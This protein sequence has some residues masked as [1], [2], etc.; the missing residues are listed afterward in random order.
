MSQ[1][2]KANFF[3]SLHVPGRPLVLYNIWDAGSARALQEAGAPAVATGSWSVAA[4]QGFDDG[5]GLPLDLLLIL[6][7][8]ITATVTCPVTVDFEGGYAVAPQ[9]VAANAARLM[10]AGAIGM[11]FEDRVVKGAGLHGI[12]DQAA[13]IVAIRQVA[14]GRDLPFGLNARTDVFLK[15]PNAEHHAALVPE[16][17]ERAAAYAQAGAS[18]LFVPG[19][20]APDLISA[21]CEGTDLPVNVMMKPGMPSIADLAALGVAR[22][23]Y[24]PGPYARAM[25][26]LVERFREAVP[27]DH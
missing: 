17:L 18:S 20:V 12:A 6:V 2:E 5:E 8:R 26:D 13:R 3:K 1:V 4:A 14:E 22:I 7:E 11:N 25:K 15:E 10:D 9:A 16:A 23:S 19:L 27:A 24:G 21:I